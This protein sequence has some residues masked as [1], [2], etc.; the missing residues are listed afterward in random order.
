MVSGEE[1]GGKGKGKRK[2]KKGKKGREWDGME[3]PWFQ[4]IFFCFSDRIEK[5]VSRHYWS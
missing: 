5:E 2:V 4:I 3:K 1:M